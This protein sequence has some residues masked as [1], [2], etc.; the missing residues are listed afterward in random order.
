MKKSSFV[1][2]PIHGKIEMP[3]W[4]VRIKDEPPI[5]RMM[6]IKQLGLKAFIDFP[7][8]IH[9]RYLHSVGTMFL[10]E[11]LGNLLIRK[12]RSRNKHRPGLEENLEHNLNSLKA[13]GFFHDIGHGPFSHVMDFVLKKEF[14]RDHEWI[15]TEVVKGFQ[16]EL[17]G[18]SMP[19]SQVNG[20]ISKE[21]QYPYLGAII[22]GPLD[23]DKVDY[24]LRDSYHVGLRYG[25]DLDQFFDNIVILG[26]VADLK[27]CELGLSRTQQAI[28]STELFL[29]LWRNMYTLVYLVESSRIA[30]K[31]LEKAILVA[32]RN[33]SSLKDD[34]KN[35]DKYLELDE[36]KLK[37]RLTNDCKGFSKEICERIFKRVS[38]YARVLDKDLQDFE[39]SRKFT[40]EIKSPNAEDD[41]SDKL[42]QGLSKLTSKQYSVI[43]DIISAKIPR[44]IHTTEKDR[45]GEP[46]EVTQ[47]SR[48]IKALSQPRTMLKVYIQPDLRKTKE[49]ATE[50][51]IK[52]EIQ[53]LIDSW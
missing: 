41:V 46:V 43:C 49:L 26:D 14:A 19:L 35:L 11:K 15:T 29:L 17:E 45:E 31:M 47:R 23:V 24:V 27:K 21:N 1:I 40:E 32:V 25:F 52:A 4:L 10:A 42:S 33:G 6:S 48:V 13:A 3:Q 2:D 7:G 9:T 12:E 22:N 53:N 30:E 39:Q 28:A 34:I 50:K 37:N 16:S 36:E 18:D 20:I 38:L 44:E 5:R 51:K 8:A